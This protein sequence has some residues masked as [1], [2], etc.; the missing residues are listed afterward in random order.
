MSESISDGLFNEAKLAVGRVGFDISVDKKAC[1]QQLQRL[2]E[3]MG[4]MISALDPTG[5]IVEQIVKE[6][7]ESK[8]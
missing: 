7:Q 8:K 3:E 5:E 2:M 1:I 6:I 4:E